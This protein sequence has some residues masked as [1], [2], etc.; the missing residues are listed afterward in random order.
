MDRRNFLRFCG[1]LVA[2]LPIINIS[3]SKKIVDQSK[4]NPNDS[5]KIVSVDIKIT[6][7]FDNIMDIGI[8]DPIKLQNNTKTTATIWYSN[9]IEIVKSEEWEC[10]RP[11]WILGND[12]YMGLTNENPVQI[13]NNMLYLKANNHSPQYFETVLKKKIVDFPS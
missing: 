5:L 9:D 10:E 8:I 1:G 12:D 7:D 13:I 3:P 2:T 11:M 4:P 6:C